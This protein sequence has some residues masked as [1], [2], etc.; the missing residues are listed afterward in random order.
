M[1]VVLG[2]LLILT[3][4]LTLAHG[5][6]RNAGLKQHYC[7]IIASTRGASQFAPLSAQLSN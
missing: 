4:T 3:E 7:S 5:L 6:Q 2:T 1:I